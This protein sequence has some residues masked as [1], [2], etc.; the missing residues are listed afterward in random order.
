MKTKIFICLVAAVLTVSCEKTPE[1]ISPTK[2]DRPVLSVESVSRTSVS[3]SW[4]P[5]ENAAS[6]DW[7]ILDGA[8]ATVTSDNTAECSF[9][10]E[11]LAAETNYVVRVKAVP[12][13]ED[14]LESDF[15]ELTVSTDPEPKQYKV[16]DL[17]DYGGVKGIVYYVDPESDG[18]SGKIVSL[19]ETWTCWSLVTENI[20]EEDASEG[21][22]YD[23]Q[24]NMDRV[25]TMENWKEN[26]PGFAWIDEKNV[27]GVT[28]WYFPSYGE[29][30]DMYAAFN[31]APGARD[32]AA[33]A[34]FNEILTSNGG[35][36]FEEV[37]YWTSTQFDFEM[38]YAV[39]FDFGSEWPWKYEVH[40]IRA[41]HTFPAPK[42]DHPDPGANII[43]FSLSSYKVNF[44]KGESTV[45]LIISPADAE[46][47]YNTVDWCTI[48]REGRNLV[49]E[50][51]A[52]DTNEGRTAEIE[53]VSAN[54]PSMKRTVTLTQGAFDLGDLYDVDGV[55][56]VVVSVDGIHGIIVSMDE[57]S[58][59]YSTEVGVSSGATSWNN[60]ML[61]YEAISQRPDWQENYPA[62][63]WCWQ[64]NDGGD[65]RWYLPAI[66]E[67]KAVYDNKD[68]VNQTL[69]ANGGTPIDDSTEYWTSNENTTDADFA[70]F[71]DFGYVNWGWGETDITDLADLGEKTLEKRV[72]AVCAY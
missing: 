13:D 54:N 11:G 3:V 51:A 16:G 49:L 45:E 6:Y 69:S 63:F 64:K 66:Y 60:G 68:M 58:A 10:Y 27:D 37:A 17:Y 67:L 52:N 70:W 23:G 55:R 19:D 8:S 30:Q 53:V 57:T 2:L 36:P 48:T 20:A 47:T 62:A 72:R 46:I 22:R 14:Y 65:V 1:V 24:V 35:E 29:M 32:D 34:A 31:G 4:A 44:D 38:G 25:R 9:Q 41:V 7:E 26:Y 39:D 59:I 56:G 71:L 43:D 21:E 42:N 28:G 15:A 33:R 40:P 18:Y 5:V 12:G 61:N 50:A